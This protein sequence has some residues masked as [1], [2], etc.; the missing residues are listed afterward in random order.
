M[1]VK[2]GFMRYNTPLQ[3]LI[4]FTLFRKGAI[5]HLDECLTTH[6]HTLMITS[7]ENLNMQIKQFYTREQIQYG[8]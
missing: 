7:G 5:L 6:F 1:K 8:I 3:D 2:W 4:L